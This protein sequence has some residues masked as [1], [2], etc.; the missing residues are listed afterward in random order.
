MKM[1]RIIFEVLTIFVFVFTRPCWSLDQSKV[2]D[3][4]L[5]NG[6]DADQLGMMI[7]D[8][9]G[10]IFALN[11]TKHLKPASTM[12][13]LTAGAA[14]EFLG[15][16]F[17]FKTQLLIDGLI[18]NHRLKGSVYM[19]AGGDPTFN[20]HSLSLFLNDLRKE[21]IQSIDGNIVIDDS[22]C[23][24]IHTLN[25]RSWSEASNPGKYPLFVNVDPPRNLQPG[26][27][28]WLRMKKKL[29]RLLELNEDYVI[30][31][32]M[33]EPD[34]WTGQDFLQL[35]SHAR[36]Y[37][38]GT[39]LR[40]EIPAEARVI[41]TVNTP[42]T[43]VIRNM[44][45]SSNNYY[46]DMMIRNLAAQSAQRP[47]NV[48]AGMQFIY[49]FLDRVGISHDDYS[50]NSGAGFTHSSYITAGAL[51]KVLNYLREQPDVSTVFVDSLPV[52]GMD[53]TLR[54][55]MRRTEAQGKV[56]AKTGYLGSVV[57][58][59]K[60]RDEVVALAGFATSSA[61]K[62]LTFVFL[63]NGTRSP[64]LVRRIFDK[65]CVQLVT[66]PEL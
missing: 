58:R 7:Q 11:E 62:T 13:I 8:E 3:T 61:G 42:L 60:I 2:L 33:V 54:Y 28:S 44:L 9:N 24:D 51:C 47:T 65:I 39:V 38:K 55:R 20:M 17:E 59:S 53:G 1:R 46:A 19:K 36:I 6:L 22:N 18:Q 5:Q 16:G 49:S 23:S 4:L 40:G 45:K 41:G 12:K 48:E 21:G 64:Y 15:T 31:Q 63:Y 34:L 30:Y 50:L 10:K 27:R 32:N 35:L 29:R 26:S 66:D 14:L 43:G 52:A 37:V 56:H 25:M 57:S